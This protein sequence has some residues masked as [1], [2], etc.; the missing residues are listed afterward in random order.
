MIG[1]A[2]RQSTDDT[3]NPARCQHD[4]RILKTYL[5]TSCQVRSNTFGMTVTVLPNTLS[6]VNCFALFPNA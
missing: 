6:A 2:Q 4:D 5:E 3:P 1:N